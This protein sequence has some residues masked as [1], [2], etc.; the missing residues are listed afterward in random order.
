MPFHKNELH[1]DSDVNEVLLYFTVRF[2]VATESQPAAFKVE[3]V[4]TPLVE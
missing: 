3:Y 4:Y 1:T 2:N